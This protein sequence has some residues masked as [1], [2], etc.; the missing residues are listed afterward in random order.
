MAVTNLARSGSAP[1]TKSEVPMGRVISASLIGSVIEWYDFLIY[2][3]A[4]AL[5]FGKLFFPS[6]DAR[7]SI[8]SAFSVYA[9]GY[10]SRPLGGLIFGH[11]GDRFGRRN[12]LM[13]SMTI[14]GLGSFL[15]GCLPTYQ[16]V[17]I[18]APVLLVALRL[19]QGLG[20]GGEWGGA[21]LMVAESAP[22]DRRGWFG[23]LVQLGNPVGR[24]IANAVFALTALIFAGSFL[25]G[26]WRIPFLL[27]ILLVA[28]GL[29]IRYRLHE[30]P[31]FV[32]MRKAGRQAKVPL[33]EV[34][35]TYRRAMFTSIGLKTCEVAWT[36]MFAIYAVSYL[37]NRLH[38]PRQFVLDAILVAAAC[39]IVVVPLAGYLS[40][41]LGR[42][43][44]FATGAIF[45]FVAAFPMFWLFNTHNPVVILPA[46]A[47]GVSLGQGI[48]YSMH[49]SLMPELF[50]TNAR[51]SGVS[52][53]FQIGAAIF[54]G[55]TPL[56]A[57]V[58]VNYFGGATWPI[59]AYL[60]VLALIS[61]TAVLSTRETAHEPMPE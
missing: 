35:T 3:T 34:L 36:G 19:V 31:A 14:M 22:A 40:D 6:A 12:M 39:G 59:S 55:I 7:I 29:F 23:G 4:A 53:G 44:V 42:R 51:Y 17:G 15:V 26:A 21:V 1:E 48:M 30:T 47:L 52:V 28:V 38:M 50:G 54:G 32:Q 27:S 43:V 2:G 60:M 41:K 10:L 5:V 24:L 49:A 37:T 25:S 13:L 16:Q 33:I 56:I 46:L 18:W 11:F 8:V 58:S 9:I 61:L 20:L 57:A 45:C